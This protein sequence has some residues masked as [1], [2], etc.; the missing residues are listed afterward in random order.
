MTVHISKMTGKLEGFQAISTNTIT[1]DYCNKQ[2]IK[3]KQDGQNICGDCYSHAMLNTYRKNMQAALQRNSDLLS[4]RPL[5]PYEIP[6]INAAMFR[7]NA[8]GELI[9]MQHLENLMAIV[10]DNPWCT[11]A[12]WT[13]RVDL[14]FRWL[15]DNGKPDN[16]NLIYSNPKKSH[17]M[18]KPPKGFDK[19]FNNV[20]E[21]EYQDRQN[22]TGQKCK[23]CRICYTIGNQINTIVE[24]V[25]K[26]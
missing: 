1:N 2:H 10:L 6:R 24:K 23:D 20:L 15:K 5:E 25:K 12:L 22:C 21:H 13:K 18:S 17:I 7:F 3:G 19:T 4:S 14:V 11:F 16:L 8:H 26:Y 9:N